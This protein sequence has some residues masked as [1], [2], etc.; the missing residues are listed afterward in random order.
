MSFGNSFLLALTYTLIQVE[1]IT[2]KMINKIYINTISMVEMYLVA[3]GGRKVSLKRAS[4][5]EPKGF[6]MMVLF[7]MFY[8]SYT[9]YIL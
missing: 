4:I 3:D 6:V 7:F 9:F 2:C 5:S 8:V 1:P